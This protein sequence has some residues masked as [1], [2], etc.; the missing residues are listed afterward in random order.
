MSLFLL[1]SLGD[2]NVQPEVE[3]GGV[4]ERHGTGLWCHELPTRSREM[5]FT[6][7]GS[8]CSCEKCGVEF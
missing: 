3:I 8:T 7:L 1:T 2:S 5:N 4:R 6:Y